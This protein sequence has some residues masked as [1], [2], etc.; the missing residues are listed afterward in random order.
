[1]DREEAKTR[2][3]QQSSKT[4]L[5]PSSP[6]SSTASRPA[7]SKSRTP[8]RYGNLAQSTTLESLDDSMGPL[9]PLGMEAPAEEVAA[10]A[11]PVKELPDRTTAP[12][13]TASSRPG[14]ATST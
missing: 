14:T 4:P 8:R 2:A 13:T 12:T 3:E 5:E 9:G 7:P 11:P 6:A 1:M 10:P